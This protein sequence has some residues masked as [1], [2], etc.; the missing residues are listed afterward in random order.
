MECEKIKSLLS[1]YLDKTL[2]N[3]EARD[4]KEHLLS[5]KNCSNDFFIMKSITGELA[6]LEKAKAPAYLLNRI[7]LAVKARPWYAKLLDFIPGSGGFRLPMEFVTFTATA[8]LVL[9]IFSNIHIDQD[10][11]TIIAESGIPQTT[12]IQAQSTDSSPLQLNFIPAGSHADML[13][14]QNVIS[15]GSGPSSGNRDSRTAGNEE[16]QIINPGR[17]V[18]ILNNIV[19]QAGGEV[20]AKEYEPLTGDVD[21]VTV[22][23]PSAGY[24]SFIRQT[25]NLG[26]FTPAAPSLTEQSSG[27]VLMRI[28][29]NLLE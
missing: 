3:D 20:I 21:T 10:G 15:V 9:M 14:S 17:L 18:S 16:G 12:D 8:A 25:E 23:I 27:P 1:E 2:G 19:Q 29:L 24:S 13:D 4:V 5:C 28:R 26:Q 6:E 7:N 11:K 22:K